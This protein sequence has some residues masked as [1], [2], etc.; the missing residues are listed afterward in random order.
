MEIVFRNP[1]YLWSLVVVPIIIVAHFLSLRYSKARAIK[2]ANFIALARVS[3]KV[4]MSSNFTVLVLRIVVFVGIVFAI[5][6]TTLHYSGSRIDA[7]Y[8]IAID[9]SVSMLAEDFSP[10]RF[11]AAKRATSIFVD[12]LPVH[13]SAGVIGFSGASYVYQPLTIDKELVGFSVDNMQILTSG[14][15]SIGDAVVTGTNLLMNSGKSRVIVLLTDGRSNLGVGIETSI[16]YANAN[17][18][19]V[20]TIG[21][22]TEE[23]YFLNISEAIG[24]L[25]VNVEEL[26]RLAS[27]TGGEF[28][29][30][31]S[32]EELGSVYGQ[33]AESKKMKVSLDLTFFLLMFIL[34]ILVVEWVLINTRYR[35]IP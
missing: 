16:N 4:R 7:D 15:T 21:V 35:I 24:P 13:I 19:I 29:H 28:Y 8:V 31:Q 27:S 6:G 18:V 33:I 9:S 14:G 1:F 20:Y 22:G 17:N 30:P 32:S 3:E 25:G 23:G 5:A 10:T 26:E 12:E 34:L 2:F 11:E